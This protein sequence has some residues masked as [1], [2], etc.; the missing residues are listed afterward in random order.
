MGDVAAVGRERW[1]LAVV[2]GLAALSGIC[3]L[4]YEVLFVRRL[5][6]LLGDTLWVHAALLST[7]LLGIA[8]GARFAH[9]A[10]RWL[11]SFEIGV[12]LY[13]VAMPGLAA[14]LAG[15]SL[16]ALPASPWATVVLTATLVALPALGIGFGLPLFSA[17]VRALRGGR[18][19]AFPDV[20]AFYNLGAAIGVLMVEVVLVRSLG[21]AGSLRALGAVSV[22]VGVGLLAVGE[23]AYREADRAG[24]R[25][26]PSRAT[27]ALHRERVE[28]G[29]PALLSQEPL[30]HLLATP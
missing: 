23:H 9:H 17:Y 6:T 14:L 2:S 18:A 29:V 13:A 26:S 21:I 11:A 3:A 24:G 1:R 19:R 27:R 20:Y 28:R 8:L 7:F 5:T 25:S 22:A 15:G 4:G 16:G 10:H 12:G 30:S